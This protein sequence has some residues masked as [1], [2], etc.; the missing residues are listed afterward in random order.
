MTGTTIAHYRVV[1][2]LSGGGMSIAC[3]AEDPNCLLLR[4]QIN[5]K[6]FRGELENRFLDSAR[7]S[8]FADDP[9]PLEMTIEN[10]K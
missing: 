6:H 9:A 2:G 8:A 3:E 5:P 10:G 1:R 4:H 7:S